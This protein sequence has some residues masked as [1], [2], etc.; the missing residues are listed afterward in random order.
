MLT[1]YILAGGNSSRM[2]R[3]KAFLPAGKVTLV[4]LVA[5]RLRP[6]VEDLHVIGHAGNVERLRALAPPVGPVVLEDFRPGCGPLMGVYTGLMHAVTPLSVFVPCDMPWVQPGL[7]DLL[8]AACVDGAEVA[9]CEVP[10]DGWH[11]FPLVCRSAALRTV[12]GLLDRDR[13]ALRDLLATPG[14]RV[15]TVSEPDLCRSF[16]NLN[17]PADH[18]RLVA[19]AH[20]S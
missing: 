14:A 8:A 5:A 18:A 9:A 1:G 16:L 12:G 2:G 19:D 4:E 15:L 7:I 13:R 17:T 10:G 6:L 3:D 11:P 20:A